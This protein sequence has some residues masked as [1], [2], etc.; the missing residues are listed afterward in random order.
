MYKVLI[1][2]DEAF[3]RDSLQH[4][5]NWEKYGY[6]I[7]GDASDGEDALRMIQEQQPD[8]VLIDVNMPKL[9]GIEVVKHCRDLELR[10]RF[11]I[12]SAHSDFK[13]VQ[14]AIHY[15]VESYLTKPVDKNEL[16]TS[17]KYIKAALDKQN[18]SDQYMEQIRL[19]AKN[20]ILHEIV[21]GTDSIDNILKENDVDELELSADVYQIVIY[22]NFSQNPDIT[23]YSFAE[24]LKVTNRGDHTFNYFEE[25]HKDVILL[26]GSY[27]LKRFQD[28]LRHYDDSAPPQKDSPM[29]MLFLAYGKPVDTLDQVH[30]SY[31]QA[32]QLIQRRFFCTQ[33][34]HTLRYDELPDMNAAA[35][36]L[37]PDLL[38]DYTE[39]LVDYLQASNRKKVGETLSSLEELLYNVKNDINQVKL[40]LIDL[41]LSIKERIN[42]LYKNNDI[43][44]A[45]NSSVISMI[46][47][48]H[49]LYEITQ[50]LLEQFEMVMN[51]TGN[52]GRN[53]VMD[54]ILYYI[55]H[56]Y[57]NNIKLETIAPLFGYNSAYLG[58]IFSKTVGENFN[59]YVDHMRIERSK[60]LLLSNAYK[61]YEIAE[62]VGY[63]NVDYF[64]KKF[65]KYVGISPAEFRKKNGGTEET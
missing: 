8:L 14:N 15:G 13:Y 56:N 54:D 21:L 44:F 45:G 10:T 26:K 58:K 30:E 39:H 12:I 31:R 48:K 36:E 1:V 55:D 61:V 43:P 17:A 60:E 53:N 64:H 4:I 35:Q 2:D 46:V 37:S 41:Y 6:F 7:C 47:Q 63:R 40:F 16:L 9:S 28:F 42:I 65:R 11:I 51:S 32:H 23:P 22:E 27:A 20:V 24:L 19:K 38:Q 50:Y 33:G 29:D 3:I 49:Y 62:K 25:D 34:Q 18:R 52:P 5:I 57:Q 59:S